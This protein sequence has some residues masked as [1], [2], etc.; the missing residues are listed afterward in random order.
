MTG[1]RW[2]D[3]EVHAVVEDK[4][5]IKGWGEGMT[6]PSNYWPKEITNKP[7]NPK[8]AVG[9]QKAPMSTLPAPVLFEMGLA[10]LEGARKYGRHNYR[11]VGVRASVYYDAFMRHVTAWWE[12]EDIDPDSGLPH[13][14]KAGACL[15]VLRD[16][17]RRGNCNDDR[18]PKV[19]DGWLKDL[20]KLASEVIDR[21]PNSEEPFTEKA[22]LLQEEKTEYSRE[23]AEAIKPSK[24][25]P[26]Y[27]WDR[28][29]TS[30]GPLPG[31]FN[32]PKAVYTSYCPNCSMPPYACV[33]SS[34]PCE[35]EPAG[36]KSDF[37]RVCLNEE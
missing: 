1:K 13:L 25:N 4:P 36:A 6:P 16:S 8:D 30:I 12:G 9:I 7:S 21:Y 2:T 37:K 27:R 28:P 34:G 22:K 35:H 24:L 18:P 3:K 20:N 31:D 29:F 11:T 33:C 26:E 14:S 10:M 32:L 17:M 23:F 19:E 15:V 5:R